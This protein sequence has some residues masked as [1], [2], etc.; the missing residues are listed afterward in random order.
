MATTPKTAEMFKKRPN[1]QLAGGIVPVS[2]MYGNSA[3]TASLS[4]D[5]A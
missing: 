4:T 1:T 3:D 2:L 5:I